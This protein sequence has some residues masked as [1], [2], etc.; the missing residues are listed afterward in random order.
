MPVPAEPTS[1]RRVVELCA[2]ARECPF[3]QLCEMAPDRLGQDSRYWLDS[4]AIKRDSMGARDR[5]E[6]RT[7]RDG[8]LGPEISRRLRDWAEFVHRCALDN[9]RSVERTRQKLL[10]PPPLASGACGIAAASW[11]SPRK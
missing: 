10:T 3:E 9:M 1:I 5:M 11:T 8:R 4:G 6:G 7:A 2:D